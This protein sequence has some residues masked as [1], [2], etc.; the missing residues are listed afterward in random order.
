LADWVSAPTD[1]LAD[2][3]TQARDRNR[4]PC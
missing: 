2:P 3:M 1:R 4:A